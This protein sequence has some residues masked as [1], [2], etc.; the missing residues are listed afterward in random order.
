[1]KITEVETL[2]LEEFPNVLWVLV[3]T[4]EGLTGLGET[5]FGAQAAEAYVHEIAAPYLLGKEALHIDRHAKELYGYLGY[6]SS[7]AET[8]GNP[9]TSSL[10]APAGRGYAPTTPAPATATC[11]SPRDRR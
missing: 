6:A 3:H 2:R 9:S 7:G 10:A 5:F 1:M 11:A 8:R 4:D